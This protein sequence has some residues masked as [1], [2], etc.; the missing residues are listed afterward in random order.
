MFFKL[1]LEHEISSFGEL[2]DEDFGEG[3]FSA[4]SELLSDCQ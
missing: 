2:V 4:D 3:L 1:F